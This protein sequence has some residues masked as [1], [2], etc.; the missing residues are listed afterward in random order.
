[1]LLAQHF[2]GWTLTYIDSLSQQDITEIFAVI[3][4]QKEAAED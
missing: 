2:P 3:R 1:V 4:A